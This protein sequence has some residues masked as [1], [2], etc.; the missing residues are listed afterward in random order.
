M[1]ENADSQES[2]AQW[3]RKADED[4]RVAELAM[5]GP[6]DDHWIVMFHAQQCV[7]K[8]LKALLIHLSIDFPKVHDVAD[9]LQLLPSAMRPEIALATQENLTYYATTGRYAEALPAGRE[10]AEAALAAA[11]SVRDAVRQHLPRN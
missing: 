10:E 8:Y 11:R 9:L 6:G 1:T 5:G 3:V 7:E 2:L 4:L